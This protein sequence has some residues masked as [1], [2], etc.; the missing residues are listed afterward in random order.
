MAMCSQKL[1]FRNTAFF[2][3][4]IFILCKQNRQRDGL[5]K[6]CPILILLQLF[7]NDLSKSNKTIS[8]VNL[9]L[10]S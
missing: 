7:F 2:F 9:V 4:E 1:L 10:K 6:A 5:K 8:I 3:V